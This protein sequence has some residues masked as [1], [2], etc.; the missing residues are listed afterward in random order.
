MKIYAIATGATVALALVVAPSAS[1]AAKEGAACKKA[2]QSSTVSGRKFTCVKKGSK[3]VW[4]KGVVV[5][6]APTASATAAASAAP[7]AP[8]MSA[9]P[10]ATKSAEPSKSAAP[11][12]TGYTMERVKANGTSSSCWTVINGYVYDLTKWIGSHP[13]GSGAITSLCGTDGTSEFLAMHRGQG[14]PEARLSGYAL[15]KLEK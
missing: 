10:M 13:G 14:K 9:T 6:S 2:G 1:A 15:G 11:A 8:A 12:S 3:L 4:N 5:K 7:A